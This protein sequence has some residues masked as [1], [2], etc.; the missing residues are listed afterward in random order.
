MTGVRSVKAG[1]VASASLLLTLAHLV[2]LSFVYALFSFS[3]IL[4]AE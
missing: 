3:S 4:M 1:V 2:S